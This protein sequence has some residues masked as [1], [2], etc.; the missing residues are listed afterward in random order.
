MEWPPRPPS[1]GPPFGVAAPSRN[2]VKDRGSR[3]RKRRQPP[4][5]R[6][7]PAPENVNAE[8][9]RSMRL[10]QG[11]APVVVEGDLAHGFALLATE[12][13]A[14]SRVSDRDNRGDTHAF[15]NAQQRLDVGLVVT[16][17][18]RRPGR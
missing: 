7:Q 16:V 4:A 9:C 11:V 14:L 18:G 6:R 8:G 1:R 17:Y 2:I 5:N 3:K 13:F 12:M 10:V 15:W